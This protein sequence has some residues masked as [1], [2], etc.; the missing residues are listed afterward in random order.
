MGESRMS[1]RNCAIQRFLSRRSLAP[2]GC[3]TWRAQPKGKNYGSVWDGEKNIAAH[4]FAYEIHFGPIPKGKYVL[5]RC[6]NRPCVNPEHLF[7]GSHIENMR[8]MAAKGRAHVEPSAACVFAKLTSAQA[9][10]I[11]AKA[12]S[13]AKQDALAAEYRVSQSTVSRIKAG[14]IWTDAHNERTEAQQAERLA[15]Q[16]RAA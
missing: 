2:N 1:C 11:R 8:D 12:L 6:D 5:H 13:G 4:R 9:F 7:L 14:R 3:I 10:E 15:A 16:L